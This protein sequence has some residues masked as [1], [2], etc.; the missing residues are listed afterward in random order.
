MG[1]LLTYGAI[2][3]KIR[4]MTSKL[5]TDKDY[6]AIAGLRNVPEAIAFLREKPGYKD[7]IDQMDSSLY[8]RRHVEKMLILSLYEDFSKLEKFAN[9]KQ[10]QYLKIYLMSYE[11]D[12][13]NYCLRIVF[14]HYDKPFDIDYRRPFFDR[15][16]K[17]SIE[18][19]I[20]STNI[21]ELVDNLKGT[22]Y[23]DP[24]HKLSD[25]KDAN[26]FDYDLT[27]QIYYYSTIWKKQ[28]KNMGKDDIALFKKDMGTEVDLMNLQ[29]IYRAKRYYHMKVADIYAL[30]IPI[31]YSL[32]IDEFKA[33]VE[34]PSI[35]EFYNVLE[36]TKYA[37]K[38]NM[39]AGVNLEK[40]SD[41]LL[42][43]L[44]KT[45]RVKNPYSFASIHTY[46]YM[47][48]LEINKITVALEGI[49]YGLGSREILSYL[50]GEM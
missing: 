41:K 24:L 43:A 13:I 38:I 31:Q 48:E 4:G 20:T 9:L 2:V 5:L 32:S 35:E 19:L 18:K 3:T 44:F 42:T 45:D 40:A 39:E 12:L 10:R 36:T 23:Y 15:Y 16:S 14:N 25:A 49:R 50:G 34:A 22:E 7:F 37:K 47:K 21:E 28:R 17:I 29:W 30:T 33:L 11:V 8:H 27:L 46:L 1:S 26:L 6:E